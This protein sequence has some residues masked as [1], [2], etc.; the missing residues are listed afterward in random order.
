MLRAQCFIN[1]G[2]SFCCIH[3]TGKFYDN[4]WIKLSPNF[5]FGRSSLVLIEK[6]DNLIP[7]T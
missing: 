2:S 5:L 1:T 4:K 7:Q 6:T 3:D